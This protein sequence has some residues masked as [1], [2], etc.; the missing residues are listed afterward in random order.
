[1]LHHKKSDDEGESHAL[2]KSNGSH[3]S[4]KE[5][6]AIFAEGEGLFETILMEMNTEGWLKRLTDNVIS[7][8]TG[9]I[10][11]IESE[12]KVGI[13]CFKDRIWF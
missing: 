13:R 11:N 2:N 10:E 12:F 1:L 6:D 3:E 8:I 5:P 9:P 4:V 7:S